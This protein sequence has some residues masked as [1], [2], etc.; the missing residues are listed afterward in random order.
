MFLLLARETCSEERGVAAPFGK[1]ASPGARFRFKKER[2]RVSGTV[3]ISEEGEG[4]PHFLRGPWPS[5]KSRY[6]KQPLLVPKH[7]QYLYPA[8]ACFTLRVAR[9]HFEVDRS[10][11]LNVTVVPRVIY[12]ASHNRREGEASKP[13]YS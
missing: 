7:G 5:N 11:K 4:N 6:R 9:G 8:L 2:R 3:S 1:L 13:D 10:T 12:L